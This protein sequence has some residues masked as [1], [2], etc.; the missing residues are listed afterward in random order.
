MEATHVDFQ[1]RLYSVCA[2]LARRGVVISTPEDVAQVFAA[3]KEEAYP[4]LAL[5][6]DCDAHPSSQSC[7]MCRGDNHYDQ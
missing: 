6:L 2:D 5:L 7:I 3:I 4:V 1:H